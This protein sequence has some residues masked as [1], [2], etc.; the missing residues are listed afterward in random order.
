[1]SP[2]PIHS[3]RFSVSSTEVL[4]RMKSAPSKS[5]LP[6]AERRKQSEPDRRR[7]QSAKSSPTREMAP[8]FSVFYRGISGISRVT[9]SPSRGELLEKDGERDGEKAKSK[10][11][12]SQGESRKCAVADKPPLPSSKAKGG[13]A[14]AA[15]GRGAWDRASAKGGGRSRSTAD[16]HAAKAAAAAEGKNWREAGEVTAPGTSSHPTP[17]KKAV[18]SAPNS[19]QQT[20]AS[21]K[22]PLGLFSSRTPQS[23]DS[24]A[25]P[26]QPPPPSI[27]MP[28]GLSRHRPSQNGANEEHPTA[29][30]FRQR[31]RLHKGVRTGKIPM[32]ALHQTYRGGS[33]KGEKHPAVKGK[34]VYL[35][36]DD[37]RQLNHDSDYIAEALRTLG[38]EQPRVA[39]S[40]PKHAFIPEDPRLL[41][42]RQKRHCLYGE[43]VYDK[44]VAESLLVCDLLQTHLNDCIAGV[45]A[46]SPTAL[47]SPF[48]TPPGSPFMSRSTSMQPFHAGGGIAKADQ[49]GDHLR[50][51]D[52]SASPTP[53]A[54]P[55]PLAP[56]P[57]RRRHNRSPQSA[58]YEAILRRHSFDGTNIAEGGAKATQP[59]YRLMGKCREYVK[60]MKNRPK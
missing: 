17:S 48:T 40:T 53:R 19:P 28:N 51:S 37:I 26:P 6:A 22:W 29:L 35:S 10:A 59:I 16:L 52:G 54:F 60:P 5:S 4:P 14:N 18:S 8:F 2:P 41:L 58:H 43:E 31:I 47:S 9:K 25:V 55:S 1:M 32:D 39:R 56:L 49:S 27:K 12:Q 36:A 23:R 3:I 50:Q 13:C 21:R 57:H 24:S 42:E 20:G 15:D 45:R 30:S 44:M 33:R 11:A 46:K 7:Q 38:D 34:S